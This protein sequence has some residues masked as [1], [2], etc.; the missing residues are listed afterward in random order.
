MSVR[1]VYVPS[2]VW[3]ATDD[4]GLHANNCSC[5]SQNHVSKSLLTFEQIRWSAWLKL[6]WRHNGR[7]SV[8]NHQPHDCLLNRL[9]RRRSKKTSKL[10]VTGL[11]A[12]NSLWPANSPHKW[13]VMRKM[14]LF[15][16]VIMKIGT[17]SFSVSPLMAFRAETW[18]ADAQTNRQT[19]TLEKGRKF[20][21]VINRQTNMLAKIINFG[22]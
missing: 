17:R 3:Y 20:G 8:S 11:G 19:N 15:D 14:S 6:Q 1:Y 22:K 7:D 2:L 4:D 13:P 5:A 21:Q 18:Q 12:G 16:D 9:F 10:H